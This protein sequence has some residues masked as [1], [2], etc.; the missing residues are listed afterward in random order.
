MEQLL[1]IIPMLGTLYGV[2]LAGVLLTKMIYEKWNFIVKK[3]WLSWIISTFIVVV[4]GAISSVFNFGV[5]ANFE[6]GSLSDWLVLLTTGLCSGLISN[7]IYDTE[8]IRNLLDLIN[9][10]K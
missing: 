4:I 1:A 9:W 2:A 5:F 3:Q 8:V 6:I 7:G 10:K